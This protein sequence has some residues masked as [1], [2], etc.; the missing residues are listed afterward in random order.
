[1]K[2]TAFILPAAVCL[3]ALPCHAATLTFGSQTLVSSNNANFD[4]SVFPGN[5]KFNDRGVGGTEPGAPT[6]Q[7]LL[8]DGTVLDYNFV[9]N[10]GTGSPLATYASGGAGLIPTPTS[11]AANVHGNGEDWANVWTTN[12]PGAGID[13]SGSTKNHNPTG[14]AE[15]VNTFARSA[16]VDGTID[17][18]GLASGQIYIGHGT[19]INNWTITLT[20]TGPGQTDVVAT[21]TQGANGP[22]TNFGWISEFN[23][24]NEGQYDT[25]AYNYSNADRDGS[26]ARFMGVV[27]DGTAIPEPSSFMLLAFGASGLFLRRR[28]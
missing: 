10:A 23:F 8:G 2:R 24:T 20:M 5:A 3:M 17:I 28:R 14:I 13:F 16:E 12:D 25:I 21:E 1:M 18:S 19:F 6:T 11:G 9:G 22:G 27:L 7:Y 26:R 15:A 4:I